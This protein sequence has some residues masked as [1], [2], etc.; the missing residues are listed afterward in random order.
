[1]SGT[2][3]NSFLPWVNLLI[4]TAFFHYHARL[5]PQEPRMDRKAEY[6]R[7][8]QEAE[9]RASQSKDSNTQEQWLRIAQA[10]RALA[11]EKRGSQTN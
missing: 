1:L 3:E 10:Y 4:A 11:A 9:E 6:L 7:R 2:L 5:R 8:A